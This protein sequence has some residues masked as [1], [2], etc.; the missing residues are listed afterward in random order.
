MMDNA[1]NPTTVGFSTL[2]GGAE[3]AAGAGVGF[4]TAG[5]GARKPTMHH[6][7][8]ARTSAFEKRLAQ[9]PGEATC[10]DFFAHLRPPARFALNTPL[11]ARTPLATAAFYAGPVGALGLLYTAVVAAFT[12]GEA[13]RVQWGLHQVE[14]ADPVLFPLTCICMMF[15]MCGLSLLAEQL[16]FVLRPG[17][18][19]LARLG[20]GSA[21]ITASA[22][23]ELHWWR[24]HMHRTGRGLG[25][26]M[27]VILILLSSWVGGLGVLITGSLL[28]EFLLSLAVAVALATE[29]TM[30]VVRAATEATPADAERWATSVE[31]PAL[32]LGQKGGAITLLSNG[33]G[34]GL[35]AV[36]AVFWGGMAPA[37]FLGVLS[38]LIW[39]LSLHHMW[40][41]W[42]LASLVVVVLL[43]PFLAAPILLS[44]GVVA[45]STACDD[46]LR[47]LNIVRMADFAHHA[48]VLKLETALNNL[49]DKQGL[50]FLIGLSVLDKAKLKTLVQAVCGCFVTA[51]PVT[52]ALY[53]TAM[54]GGAEF[55]TIKFAPAPTYGVLE[56]DGTN[57]YTLPPSD[58]LVLHANGN[59]FAFGG[60]VKMKDT[61]S[62]PSQRVFDF[63]NGPDDDNIM[64]R[65]SGGSGQ[66]M[67]DI[68]DRH[69]LPSTE[70]KFPLGRWVHV[71]V[72][73]ANDNAAIYWDGIVK[74]STATVIQ[75]RQVVRRHNYIGMSN[76]PTDHPTAAGSQMH[77]LAWY[78]T[79]NIT[80]EQIRTTSGPEPTLSAGLQLA[81]VPIHTTGP[82]GWLALNGTH[83][84][85]DSSRN[86]TVAKAFDG[87]A[88]TTFTTCCDATHWV[89][90]ALPSPQTVDRYFLLASDGGCPSG[91][92]F[93]AQQC[94]YAQAFPY[95]PYLP[96]CKWVT[97]DSR[98]GEQ[99]HNHTTVD[100]AIFTI[101]KDQQQSASRYRWLFKEAGTLA[102]LGLGSSATAEGQQDND[103][104]HRRAQGQEQPEQHC[105]EAMKAL[106]LEKM[107]REQQTM[108]VQ[109]QATIAELRQEHKESI[110]EQAQQMSN[111]RKEHKESMKEQAG[112]L[113][114]KLDA[115]IATMQAMK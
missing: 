82:S 52:L 42:L 67:Y 94:D 62:P 97:L 46:V 74:A 39:L 12:R 14:D 70:E 4:S 69:G 22:L 53:H 92:Q 59:A 8:P 114:G 81:P 100:P 1:L 47:Q 112:K 26:V 56:F 99:C 108:I 6:S 87:D 34:R 50:G 30:Q 105:E 79:P 27:G 101:P 37:A 20:A 33:W 31:A 58:N 23:R 48:A 76:R 68:P 102:E 106:K 109:Q 16:R 78:N 45:T 103:N 95:T 80:I 115:I 57:A 104:G 7:W 77:G 66:M 60:W 2:A 72:I 54:G 13:E 84:A 40:L 83:S 18:G 29:G 98:H 5:A 93:Q 25:A 15:V 51:V 49:N 90:Y 28:S 17:D 9:E 111:M 36:Y 64:L 32:A 110:K 86:P 43:I 19:E 71:A 96:S 65:F 107:M 61:S 88:T 21:K 113:E 35:G 55:T 63:G 11:G 73:H 75:P 91:W 10:P 24:R 85:A 41:A 38:I 44:K 89:E 3:V